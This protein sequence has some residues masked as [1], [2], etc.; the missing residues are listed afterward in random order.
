MVVHN[1]NINYAMPRKKQKIASTIVLA[2]FKFL[3]GRLTASTGIIKAGQTKA[4]SYHTLCS[5]GT[6]E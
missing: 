2:N 3:I 4:S 6:V 5:P 1:T